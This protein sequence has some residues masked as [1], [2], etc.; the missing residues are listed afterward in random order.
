M[1]H[2]QD[3][4]KLRLSERRELNRSSGK[5]S[6]ECR[7]RTAVPWSLNGSKSVVEVALIPYPSGKC[8]FNLFRDRIRIR[9]RSRVSVSSVSPGDRHRVATLDSASHCKKDCASQSFFGDLSATLKAEKV[10]RPWFRHH[11]PDSMALAGPCTARKLG[12]PTG[13]HSRAP[14]AHRRAPPRVQ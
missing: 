2:F 3:R 13:R 1:C 8:N 6:R 7:T 11:A 5:C 10:L 4:V 9:I 12:E 14:R